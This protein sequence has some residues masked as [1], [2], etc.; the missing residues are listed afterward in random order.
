MNKNK[1]IYLPK[2][3]T[4]FSPKESE[5]RSGNTPLPNPAVDPI[6]VNNIAQAEFDY[7]EDL[8]DEQ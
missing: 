4:D 5:I 2:D 8:E 3:R 1:S 6:V 7:T